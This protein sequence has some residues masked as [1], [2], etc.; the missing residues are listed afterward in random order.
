VNAIKVQVLSVP[1][2]YAG[3]R[4]TVA[5]MARLIR[6]GA[7]SLSVRQHAIAVLR[8]AAIC[9]KD[10]L[11]EIGALLS[12]VQRNVRYTRDPHKV[13]TLHSADRMLQFR[14]GDCDDMAVLLGA[15]LKSVGHPVRIVITGPDAR[16][17]RLFSHVYLEAFHRGKWIP[18]DPTMP[19]AM[20]WAPKT[21]VQERFP[22]EP[23]RS[24]VAASSQ[25]HAGSS[26][27]E[28]AR[29]L[30]RYF[31]GRAAASATVVRHTRTIPP[32]VVD[33]GELVGIMY[34]SDKW[35]PDRPRT[36]VHFMQDRPR[37]VSDP[38]GRQLYL[39]G[40]RYRI[41]KRGIEG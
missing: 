21:A 34:R 12:W 40:G 30:Y 8:A 38:D 16:R 31:A 35:H 26:R 20:G 5:E 15:L 22:V 36:Y 19:H 41:T 11:G 7:K 24:R 28:D 17:P 25:G 27:V 1:P 29:N 39:V 13:E 32:V 14:A 10:Y 18:L 2:G 3:T 23:A 4:R 37:L 33:L 6:E 9:Q